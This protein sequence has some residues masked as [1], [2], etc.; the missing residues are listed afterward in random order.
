MI[1]ISHCLRGVKMLNYSNESEL[2]SAATAGDDGAMSHLISEI[3]PCIESVASTNA[4]NGFITRSDLIQEGLIG[5]INAIFSFDC[6]KGVKFSTYAEKCILNSITSAVRKHNRQKQKLLNTYVPLEDV[7][8]SLCGDSDNPET[9]V[10]ME[11][12]V[13]IITSCID[14]L[15]TPLEREVL[16]MHIADC[17]CEQIS[18]RLD[19]NKKA[20]ANALSRARKKIRSELDEKK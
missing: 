20:V 11:E 15:L 7:E 6:S 8:N 18:E 17:S 1:V 12:N 19:I 3:M 9:V 13:D 5:A 14:E 4:G 16:L 10:S 2:I